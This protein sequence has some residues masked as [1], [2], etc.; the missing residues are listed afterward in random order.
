LELYKLEIANAL[1]DKRLF[2][3]YDEAIT[4]IDNLMKTYDFELFDLVCK[5]CNGQHVIL[6]RQ[7]TLHR[8]GML[9]F[10]VVANKEMVI[11]VH[12][13]ACEPFNADFDG[14]Q[15]A[16]Y[17]A[18]YAETEAECREKLSLMQ[19]LL[20]PSTGDLIIGI[21]QDIVLGLYLLTEPEE[22]EK[23]VF[24]YPDGEKV[25]T[26][27]GRIKFNKCLPDGYKFWNETMTKTFLQLILNDVARTY[28]L[29]EVKSVLDKIKRLGFETTT[30]NGSTL[31][32]DG[33]TLKNSAKLAAEI[34]EDDSLS[35][36]DRIIKLKSKEVMDQ[37]KAEFGSS[38]FIESGSR[39]SWDQACQIVLSRGY[40]SNA[41]GRIMPE[42]VKSN[43]VDGLSPDEFFTSSYGTRKGLLDV[44]MN[45]GVSGYLTR[46]TVFGTAN[47]EA[48]LEL[49]D[50]GTKDT[51]DLT[52]DTMKKARCLVGRWHLVNKNLE[53]ITWENYKDVLN[54]T[55]KLRSPIMCTSPKICRRCYGTTLD[56]IH[57]KYVGVLAAQALGEVSTQLVMRTFHTSGVAQ[58]GKGGGEQEDIISD[59]TM[60]RSILHCNLNL[61]SLEILNKL[62]NIYVTHRKILI[63]H[64][65]CI[66]SQ[67]M[68]VGSMRWRLH[69]DRNTTT[70]SM[71][72]ILTV[73]QLD[74]W[75]LA[76]AFHR[77]KE[78]IID[79]LMHES[80]DEEG[81]LEKIMTN[82]KI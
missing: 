27:K 73:P 14:D 9:S 77:P 24:V 23:D 48:N 17:R 28:P 53:E 5:I 63:V 81:F 75:L 18:L 1:I 29:D 65:E 12:P 78:Y 26:Y 45:T 13:M 30:L 72:S 35:I 8:M 43:F 39:G 70:P 37:V 49:E 66:V 32:L 34:Y 60:V 15:M 11:Q 80:P 68:R 52:V 10:K 33:M 7:P 62:F 59:L 19:N 50:C 6:N 82:K 55:I 4:H 51:I 61:T 20:S 58:I 57:T 71:T 56:Y 41:A 79:G 46:K 22:D 2:K 16:V 76:L 3:E 64:F 69:K 36:S 67:M 31:S 40:V 74:S 47:L 42:P 38:S 44:A 54:K 21:N 25:N